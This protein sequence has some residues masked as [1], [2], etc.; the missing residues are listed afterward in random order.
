MRVIYRVVIIG[1]FI[2]MTVGAVALLPGIENRA[3][4]TPAVTTTQPNPN[5][6]TL[7]MTAERLLGVPNYSSYNR[8]GSIGL[9]QRCIPRG[10]ACVINGTPC[11]AG[12]CQGKFPYTSCR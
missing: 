10:Q 8:H 5:T 12:S 7:P 9:A 2:A 3:Q 1:I 11:C 4:A 6:G